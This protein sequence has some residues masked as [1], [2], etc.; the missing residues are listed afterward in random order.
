MFFF[1]GDIGFVQWISV[2]LRSKVILTLYVY[3]YAVFILLKYYIYAIVC[4]HA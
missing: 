3:I 2:P 1:L 4:L